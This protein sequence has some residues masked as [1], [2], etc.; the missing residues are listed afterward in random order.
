MRLNH[1]LLLPLLLTTNLLHAADQLDD[2][3]I[4]LASSKKLLIATNLP[5]SAEED[6]AFWPLYEIYQRELAV[7]DARVAKLMQEYDDALAG[8]RLSDAT[9]M[10]LTTEMLA[11]EAEEAA[12]RA[13]QLP[14]LAAV[15]P[16]RLVA[17]YLQL[18]GK[19]RALQRYDRSQRVPLV[20]GP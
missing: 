8:D 15:L 12:M 13:S 3:R 7:I 11:I 4:K 6:H 1:L 2:V 20:P 17:R 18:E 10:R 14:R 5:L 19:I 16:A 9:A